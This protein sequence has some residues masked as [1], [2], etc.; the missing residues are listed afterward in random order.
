[1][2]LLNTLAAL[3]SLWFS[4]VQWLFYW[5]G[6]GTRSVAKAGGDKIN[7]INAEQYQ[8]KADYL[9]SAYS[10]FSVAVKFS[11]NTHISAMNYTL[12]LKHK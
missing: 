10:S 9:A 2:D 3:T 5:K 4:S 1:M 7:S 11:E 12:S 6:A 8:T